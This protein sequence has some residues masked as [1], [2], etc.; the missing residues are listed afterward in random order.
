[1]LPALCAPQ[2]TGWG[3]LSRAFPLLN[4]WITTA[5]GWSASTTTAA[6]S[7]AL[8]FSGL[9]GI[10]A[11]RIVDHRGPRTTM[12][13]GSATGV[14]SLVVALAPNP[15]VF[16][17]GWTWPGSPCPPTFHQPAFAAL[18]RRWAPAQGSCGV[19]SRRCTTT[20]VGTARI[21]PS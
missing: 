5:T 3:V 18:T 2:I 19:T 6:F 15:A 1:M 8:V 14:L 10:R 17:T 9:V 13:A 21:N 7:L 20:H 11:D 4:P 12:T 16:F